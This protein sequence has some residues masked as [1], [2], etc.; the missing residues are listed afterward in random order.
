M[1]RKRTLGK[2]TKAKPVKK[3]KSTKSSKIDRAVQSVKD[4]AEMKPL[5]D[6]VISWKDTLSTGS[7]LLD[8]AI[9]SG[10]KYGGGIPGGI[11][12]EIFGKSSSG[13][14]SILSELC[15]SAQAK[16]GDILF[17]DPEARLDE[18]YA[19]IYGVNINKDA[20]YQPDTVTEM[21]E[22]FSSWQP[23]GKKGA[24]NVVAADSLAAL[25]TDLELSD[26]GDKMGMRRAKEFSQELRKHARAINKNNWILA[27]SNQV[28]HGDYGD[29][30]PGGKAVG[31]YS[32]LRISVNQ[33]EKLYTE[34]QYAWED[35]EGKKRKGKAIKKAY[36]I[37][38]KCIVTKSS[39]DKPYR[40]VFIYIIFDY[41]IDNIRGN[42]QWLK[43]TLG[44]TKY[45]AVDKEYAQIRPAIDYIENNNLEEALA[46]EV[47]DLWNSVEKQF[48]HKRK[49]KER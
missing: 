25:S 8:L 5:G 42:L 34:R 29:E 3:T 10:R 17:L 43:D 44:L 45:K 40:E 13:K 36:G 35:E 1:G 2:D 21:F 9:S 14:T 48:V 6:I 20:Y 11:L 12:V 19:R 33:I 38:S 18:E 47:I 32:S 26:K 16:G 23:Q 15:G 46:K 7:T 37:K 49:R 24:I 39:I 27:C 30:T 31:F 4:S 41:G 22:H 28:R